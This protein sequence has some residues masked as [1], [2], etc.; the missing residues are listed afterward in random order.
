MDSAAAGKF[1]GGPGHIYR[2]QYLTD[3]I[4]GVLFGNGSRE[5]TVPFGIFGGKN[6]KTNVT[7]LEQTDGQINTIETNSFM[8]VK[9]GDIITLYGMGGA[10]FGDPLERDIVKVQ[11]DVINQFVSVQKAK[12]EY[13]V[14]VNPETFEVD[15]KATESLR[16][17]RMR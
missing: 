4:D 3:T 11:Q 7:I 15:A 1:R 13:G 12:E 16:H 2:V 9:A 10:G 14:V 6:P 5:D 17:N 8:K